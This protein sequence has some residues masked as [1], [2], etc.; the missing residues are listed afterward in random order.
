MSAGA[1]EGEPNCELSTGIMSHAGHSHR[2]HVGPNHVGS[3]VRLSSPP[4]PLVSHSSPVSAMEADVDQPA[5][6]LPQEMHALQDTEIEQG[7]AVNSADTLDSPFS[8]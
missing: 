2:S 3:N 1:V 4:T 6:T 7:R 8:L 5:P